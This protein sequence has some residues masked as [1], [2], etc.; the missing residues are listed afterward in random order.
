MASLIAQR[1]EVG[2]RG[3]FAEIFNDDGHMMWTG[4]HCY[5]NAAGL[6]LPKVAAGV[7]ECKRGIHTIPTGEKF[8]TFE[9][10]NVPGHTGILFCHPGNLPQ[11]D[12]DGCFLCGL[13]LGWLK[14]ARAIIMSR[15]AF[16]LFTR[17]C[18]GLD[19]FTLTIADP[20]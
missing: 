19:S 2:P 10:Q 15:N 4:E 18:T 12:S 17:W 9:V 16:A 8:D 11:V 7:W 1:V 3:S 13:S 5:Q 6:W 14:S 20:I